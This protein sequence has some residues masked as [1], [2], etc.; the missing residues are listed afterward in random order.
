MLLW[1]GVT[2]SAG[3]AAG[4]RTVR[5]RR[6]G[7]ARVADQ[8][9]RRDGHVR[10]ELLPPLAVFGLPVLGFLAGMVGLDG[11]KLVRLRPVVDDGRGRRRGRRALLRSSTGG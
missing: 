8:V 7:H 11:Y 3:Y 4:L 9:R 2:V 10:V 5:A 6:Q 1:Y